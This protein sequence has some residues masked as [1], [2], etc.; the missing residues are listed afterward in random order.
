MST[1]EVNKEVLDKISELYASVF[2]HDGFGEIR[3]EM[4]ILR[5]GQK[6][7]IIHCGKQYRYIIDYKNV[8]YK[9]E[10]LKNE[11]DDQ[12]LNIEKQLN[13]GLANG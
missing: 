6:E 3:I 10:A 13:Y 1:L 4:K 2:E 11:N 12:S 5:R 7:V 8:D 9:N